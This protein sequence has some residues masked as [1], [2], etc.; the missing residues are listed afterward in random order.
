MQYKAKITR[1]ADGKT[2]IIDFDW[3]S[4]VSEEEAKDGYT[5]EYYIDWMWEEGNYSCNCNHHLF[6]E[7]AEGTSE[8]E[9]ED[10]SCCAENYEVELIYQ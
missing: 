3:A 7:R 4:T 1:K 6:F 9:I 5:P 10:Q 2:H 8:E